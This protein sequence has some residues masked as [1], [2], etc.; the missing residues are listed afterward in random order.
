LEPDCP[1][2]G[3]KTNTDGDIEENGFIFEI[4]KMVK[5]PSSFWK[6]E[7]V[8]ERNETMFYQRDHIKK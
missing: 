3:R 4:S 7:N 8:K 1:I 5:L 6:S 2:P